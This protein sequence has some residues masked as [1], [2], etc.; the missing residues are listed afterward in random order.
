MLETQ[1]WQ[2]TGGLVGFGYILRDRRRPVYGVGVTDWRQSRVIAAAIVV[3]FMLV[4]LAV[5]VG[6]LA[7]ERG[8]RFGWQMYSRVV[9]TTPEF[10]VTTPTGTVP[11]ELGDYLPTSRIEVD[12]RAHLPAHLCEVIPDAE[13]VSWDE[14]SHPC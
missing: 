7:D 9:R 13:S 2:A 1:P 10:L 5:P 14:G 6:R 11:I 8:Q 4:Q 12:V 3:A